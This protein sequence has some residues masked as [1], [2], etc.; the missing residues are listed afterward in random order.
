MS[1]RNMVISEALFTAWERIAASLF[2][3]HRQKLETRKHSLPTSQFPL[4][5]IILASITHHCRLPGK[6]AASYFENITPHESYSE[7]KEEKLS[8]RKERVDL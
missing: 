8:P 7:K 6:V 4:I 1:E 2:F 5:I 3:F